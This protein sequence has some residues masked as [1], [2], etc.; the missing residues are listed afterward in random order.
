LLEWDGTSL[1]ANRQ[2]TTAENEI[3]PENIKEQLIVELTLS[4]FNIFQLFKKER[5]IIIFYFNNIYFIYNVIYIYILFFVVY[6]IY[7]LFVIL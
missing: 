5:D 4:I 3:F 6:I 2:C 7:I 1:P